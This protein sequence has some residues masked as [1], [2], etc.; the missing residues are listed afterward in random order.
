MAGLDVRRSGSNAMSSA[1]DSS[2]ESRPGAGLPRSVM[3]A[4]LGSEAFLAPLVSWLNSRLLIVVG[5]IDTPK[6]NVGALLHFRE[7]SARLT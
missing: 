2:I 7:R 6:H 3:N 4:G 1:P 5:M